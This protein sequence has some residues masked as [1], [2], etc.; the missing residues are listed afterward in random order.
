[1]DGDN[2]QR[3]IEKLTRFQANFTVEM[4]YQCFR[5]TSDCDRRYWYNKYLAH[6]NTCFNLLS[7]YCSLDGVNK[8]LFVDYLCNESCELIDTNALNSA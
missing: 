2:L 8:N 3:Y 5:V 1:M 4:L 6:V 7:F